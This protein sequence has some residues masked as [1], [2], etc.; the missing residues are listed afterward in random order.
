LTQSANPAAQRFDVAHDDSPPLGFDPA[1][2]PHR[3]KRLDD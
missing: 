2:A 1:E 3:L